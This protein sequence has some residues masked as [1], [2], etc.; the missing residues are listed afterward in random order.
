MLELRNSCT[1]L[2]LF[3]STQAVGKWHLGFCNSSY[4]PTSRGFHHH[5]G[6]WTGAEDYFT[7]RVGGGYDLRDD[8]EVSISFNAKSSC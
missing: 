5:Y 1:D 4:L 6:Y 3:L 7:H 8:L 2:Y